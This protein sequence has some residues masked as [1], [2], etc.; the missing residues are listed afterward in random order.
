MAQW[1]KNLTTA[2]QVTAEL[3][4]Q[5][6]AW[7]SGLKDLVLQ[8]LWLRFISLWPGNFHMPWVQPLKKKKK[9]K[10]PQLKDYSSCNLFY[11]FIVKYFNSDFFKPLGR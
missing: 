9:K 7:H 1:V 3:R 8:Q 2:T 4:V 10:R 6:L 5:S 11:K